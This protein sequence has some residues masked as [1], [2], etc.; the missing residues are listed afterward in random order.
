MMLMTTGS[1][2]G[3][4]SHRHFGPHM[5]RNYD[6]PPDERERFAAH[7]KDLK[8]AHEMRTGEKYQVGIIIILFHR[9]RE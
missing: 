6:I 5:F 2:L 7:D 8:P 3:R 1:A 9:S 4:P